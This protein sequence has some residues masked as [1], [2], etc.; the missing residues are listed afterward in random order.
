MAKDFNYNSDYFIKHPAFTAFSKIDEDVSDI[1]YL[2]IIARLT[3]K[4]GIRTETEENDDRYRINFYLENTQISGDYVVDWLDVL[5]L[6][7]M[8]TYYVVKSDPQIIKVTCYRIKRQKEKD[9]SKK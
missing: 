7:D 6:S 3:I 4:C 2:R 9:S 5:F 1:E 8:H